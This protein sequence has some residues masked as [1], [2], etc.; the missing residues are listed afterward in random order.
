MLLPRALHFP[1]ALQLNL[2]ESGENARENVAAPGTHPCVLIDFP[3]EKLRTICSLLIVA[4]NPISEH[5]IVYYNG[6]TFSANSIFCIVETE[7]AKV[8]KRAKKFS[9][10]LG[11]QCVC[12][13]LNDEEVVFLRKT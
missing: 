8:S 6:T 13:I 12:R 4:K 3:E 10:V 7:T 9:I 5:S 11:T 2:E 1:V